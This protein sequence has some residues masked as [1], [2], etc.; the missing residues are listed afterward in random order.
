MNCIWKSKNEKWGILGVGH[1][2]GISFAHVI[3][4]RKKLAFE[5]MV[6]HIQPGTKLLG[7]Q[8]ATETSDHL[9]PDR[10]IPNYFKEE[11]LRLIQEH[12][13]NK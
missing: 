12:K 7:G 2:N 9:V 10:P 3:D 1:E 8:V 5:V 11:I 4:L 13:Q 6:E